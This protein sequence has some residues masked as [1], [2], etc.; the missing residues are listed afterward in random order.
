MRLARS[1]DSVTVSGCATEL[2]EI[3]VTMGDLLSTADAPAPANA[4][5]TVHP[6]PATRSVAFTI[7]T[8]TSEPGTLTIHDA[9]GRRIRALR[10]SGGRGVTWDLRD[11]LG[12]DVPA[13]VYWSVLS[14]A[15]RRAAERVVVTR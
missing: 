10:W 1:A 5:L 4:A 8:P 15:T 2:Y 9:T 11:E 14:D 7:G 6:Q 13:G 3:W 12:R